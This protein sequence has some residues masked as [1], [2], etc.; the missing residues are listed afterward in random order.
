MIWV[1]EANVLP[2]YRLRV[3][4]SDGTEGEVDLK[5]FIAASRWTR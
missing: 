4:F 1:T 3:R 2:D 5:D